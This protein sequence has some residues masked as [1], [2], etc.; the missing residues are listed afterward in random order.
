[1]SQK[2][3][4]LLKLAPIFSVSAAIIVALIK[5][6]SWYSTDSASVLASLMDALLDLSTSAINL[7]ALR[8]ALEPPDHN[9]RFGH[10]KVED[11]AVFAQSI[12]FFATGI[13][14]L[15]SAGSHITHQRDIANVEIGIGS[16]AICS[17]ITLMLV[18]YQT[19]VIHRTRSSIIEADRLHYF[20][21]LLSNL[22]V[23]ASLYWSAQYWYLD[24]ILGALIGLYIMKGSYGLFVRSLKNLVDH[25]MNDKERQKI[26]DIISK[27]EE[28]LGIHELKTRGAGSKL[29][30]QFHLELNG[31]MSLFSAHE[32][33]DRIMHDIIQKFPNAEVTIHQDPAGIEENQP[34][35]EE[36]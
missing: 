18:G 36:L 24:P 23:M 16:M 22:L 4:R 7:V 10:N 1:M 25:E 15:Y 6:Y 19:F 12:A 9:H 30:I 27:H 20:T 32:I 3:L 21:D 35:R 2:N 17:I 26:I 29:F 5:S 34:Y 13:L 14:A 31:S 8:V 11:L 28:V 33:S